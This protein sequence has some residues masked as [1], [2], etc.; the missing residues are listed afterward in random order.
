MNYI[1][2]T[3]FFIIILILVGRWYAKLSRRTKYHIIEKKRDI[4]I[5]QYDPYIIA[6][7]QAP[8]KRKESI[9]YGFIKLARYIFG[10][11]K[12][13]KKIAMTAPVLQQESPP[14]WDICFIMPRK[15]AFNEVPKPKE[16]SISL[17]KIKASTFIC[18]KFSGNPTDE[19]LQKKLIRLK[20]FIKDRK[21]ATLG[22][23]IY[24]FY[25]P[26]WTIPIFRRNEIWFEVNG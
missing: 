11:N 24:A 10:D 17:K 20:Q 4:E 5:R 19:K 21:I 15:Y 8:G 16:A 7:I 26:P 25:N 6:K 3:I 22:N 23:P 14:V 12:S 1:Y 2:F 18:I 9:R 13:S